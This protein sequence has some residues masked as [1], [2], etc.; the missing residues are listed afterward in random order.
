[1]TTLTLTLIA[2]FALTLIATAIAGLAQSVEED[3]PLFAQDR[4]EDLRSW[5]DELEPA[6]LRAEAGMPHHLTRGHLPCVDGVFVQVGGDRE[7]H[8]VLYVPEDGPSM[9][10]VEALMG[11]YVPTAG[12][13]GVQAT[14]FEAMQALRPHGMEDMNLPY[15]DSIENSMTL[16]VGMT[17]Y[18]TRRSPSTEQTI[19]N[20]MGHGWGATQEDVDV[21]WAAY[22]TWM[23]R[24]I[25]RHLDHGISRINDSVCATLPVVY[26]AEDEL[27]LGAIAQCFDDPEIGVEFM[28]TQGGPEGALLIEVRSWGGYVTEED[29]V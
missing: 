26:M 21:A 19:L 3:G 23:D 4:F 17:F 14:L 2:L 28:V 13:D 12:L 24:K 16:D 27:P 25:Q 8:V 5:L 11:E 1:M 18:V 15:M 29:V 22:A 10:E 7:H 9:E 20:P 6:S